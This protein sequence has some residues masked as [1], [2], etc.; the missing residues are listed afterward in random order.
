VPAAQTYS[1]ADTLAQVTSVLD[2]A[3]LV[4]IVIASLALLAGLVLIANAVALALLERRRELGILKAV[5]YTSRRV[6]G[7]VLLENG[8]IGV[9]GSVLAMLLV[10]AATPL[11]GQAIYGAPFDVPLGI[12]L[13]V[14]PTSAVVCVLVAGGVAWG[15]ARVRPLEVLRYE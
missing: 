2:D 12:V 1:L 3:T 6:L 13:V 4:L 11:L 15:A 8:A 9:V 14:I 7:A 5:G 10:A